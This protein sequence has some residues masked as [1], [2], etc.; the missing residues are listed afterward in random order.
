LSRI[1]R[2]KSNKLESNQLALDY[3][4]IARNMALDPM[5][6]LDKEEG[7]VYAR[8]NQ[9]EKSKASYLKYRESLL[10]LKSQG[11]NVDTELRMINQYIQRNSGNASTTV[12][13]QT[14]EPD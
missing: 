13:K 9:S 6:E 5:P 7:L 12:A 4:R 1:Q 2:R 8:L 11:K 3:L 10:E 14:D